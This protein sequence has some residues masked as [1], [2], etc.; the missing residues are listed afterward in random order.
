[1]GESKEQLYDLFSG[2]QKE[3]NSDQ[4]APMLIDGTKVTLLENVI[5]LG[6][7]TDSMM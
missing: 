3:C 4:T 2:M 5:M 6:Q 7:K 1:M